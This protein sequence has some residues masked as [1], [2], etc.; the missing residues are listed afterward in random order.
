MYIRKDVEKL[1]ERAHLAIATVHGD[2]M[3]YI[4]KAF[5]TNWVTTAGENI[6]ELEKLAAE[7]VGVKCAAGLSAG[8]AALHLCMKLAAEKA[9]GH[10]PAGQGCFA[11]KRVFASDTTFAATVF[12]A[13]YEGANLTLID[14]ERDTWNMDPKALRI[15]KEKIDAISNA[16]QL[17]SDDHYSMICMVYDVESDEYKTE[18]E[19][20][21]NGT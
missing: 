4:Q 21:V 12:P 10:T 6:N 2:E 14:S 8:T 11:G 19:S 1:A 5:D 3:Q 9:F 16:L 18:I 13:M 7:K 20:G 17:Y 15:E